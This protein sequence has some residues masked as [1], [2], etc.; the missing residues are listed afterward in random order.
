M[1]TTELSELVEQA[2]TVD[3]TRPNAEIVADI[4][5]Q[6]A[7]LVEESD[8]P[9]INEQVGV[10]NLLLTIRND[11]THSTLSYFGYF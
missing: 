5:L 4:I 11:L 9:V 7:T 3:Q 10:I 2:E 8:N 6:I 1:I